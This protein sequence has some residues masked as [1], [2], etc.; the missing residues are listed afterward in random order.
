MEKEELKKLLEKTKNVLKGKVY[1]RHKMKE[2]VKTSLIKRNTEERS[3]K[4]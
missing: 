2:K 1:L 4:T 3:Q